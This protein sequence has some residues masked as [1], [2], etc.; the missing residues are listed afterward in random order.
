MAAR[1]FG[2]RAGGKPTL[3]IDDLYAGS[4]EFLI[5]YA[6]AKRAGLKVAGVA[7]SKF[8]DVVQAM[9]TFEVIKKLRS[10]V[11]LDVTH[12]DPG[13]NAS[14]ITDVFGASVRQ[15]GPQEYNEAYN[16]VDRAEAKKWAQRRDQ[17]RAEGD[18]ADHRGD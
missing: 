15:V 10:S 18:G 4:G 16:N 6:A 9:K 8:D 17:R 13:T 5:S 1:R 7:S 12:R 3:F 11:I 14:A 2:D